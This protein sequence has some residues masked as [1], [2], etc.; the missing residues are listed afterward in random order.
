MLLPKSSRNIVTSSASTSLSPSRSPSQKSIGSTSP[1]R[2]AHAKKPTALSCASHHPHSKENLHALLGLSSVPDQYHC[3]ILPPGNSGSTL[4]NGPKSLGYDP[5]GIPNSVY[6]KY[7]I[8]C[9]R[10]TVNKQKDHRVTMHLGSL[11]CT[12]LY[13]STADPPSAIV[14]SPSIV[15]SPSC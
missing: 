12:K 7:R 8:S 6:N 13:P 14:L 11:S 2:T 9:S 3:P 5:Q 1:S 4:I 10:L 15:T